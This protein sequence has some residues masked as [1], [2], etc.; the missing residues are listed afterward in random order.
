MANITREK[1]ARR[2]AA[3]KDNDTVESAGSDARIENPRTPVM[4]VREGAEPVTP[5]AGAFPVGEPGTAAPAPEDDPVEAA[6]LKQEAAQ[7]VEMR[8]VVLTRDYF[9]RDGGA[10]LRAVE[11]PDMDDAIELPIEEARYVEESGIGQ[12][13]DTYPFRK[14]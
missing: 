8:K 9:P 4:P 7:R 3:A 2:E 6:K 1:R 14:R 5:A 10:R 12:S 13:V 11:D